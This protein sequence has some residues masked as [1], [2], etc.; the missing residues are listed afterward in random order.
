M[1][2]IVCKIWAL[3]QLNLVWVLIKIDVSML[4]M[5]ARTW[6]GFLIIAYSNSLSTP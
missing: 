2:S 5:I 1:T 4:K 6:K 3:G